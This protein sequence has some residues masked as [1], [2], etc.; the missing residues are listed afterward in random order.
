M[1]FCYNY[2]C[3]ENPKILRMTKKKVNDEDARCEFVR[4]LTQSLESAKRLHL[5]DAFILPWSDG[6]NLQD[7]YVKLCA[8]DPRKA[9]EKLAYLETVIPL[10][11]EPDFSW[12]SSENV[13][14]FVSKF[15][16]APKEDGHSLVTYL[17]Y[18]SGLFDNQFTLKRDFRW[19]PKETGAW[20]ICEKFRDYT[21]GNSPFEIY[22]V[23]ELA[24]F[25]S[26]L[27]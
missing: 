24:S 10:M 26:W 12:L 20:E 21:E 16:F 22:D 15:W 3:K 27:N 14:E 13:Q 18:V 7:L 2:Y 4:R 9:E 25:V 23:D 11:G 17:V 1:Y 5:V 19:F 6:E 8:D